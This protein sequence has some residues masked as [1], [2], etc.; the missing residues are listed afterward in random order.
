M[1]LLPAEQVRDQFVFADQSTAQRCDGSNYTGAMTRVRIS[2]VIA[3]LGPR[4]PAYGQLAAGQLRRARRVVMRDAA[5][6]CIVQVRP[7]GGDARVRNS[8]GAIDCGDERRRLRHAR[9]D[10][11]GTV[12]RRA[13][14]DRGDAV[15]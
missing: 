14:L 8:N 1:G 15:S 10:D 11:Y 2:D 6:E 12:G 4:T 7:A 3:G 13:A 5:G 9:R